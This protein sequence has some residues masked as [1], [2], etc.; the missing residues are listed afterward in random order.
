[1]INVV[2]DTWQQVAIIGGC[3]GFLLLVFLCMV[4]KLCPGCCLYEYC[5]LKAVYPDHKYENIRI[6]YK[7]EEKFPTKAYKLSPLPSTEYIYNLE[8]KGTDTVNGLFIMPKD[9]GSVESLPMSD[10]TSDSGLSKPPRPNLSFTLSY[11][12]K[13]EKLVINITEARNL[14]PK[15]ASGVSDFFLRV[16]FIISKK[17]RKRRQKKSTDEQE[18]TVETNHYRRSQDLEIQETLAMSMKS[19]ELKHAVLKF[20]ACEADRYSRCR[21]LGQVVINLKEISFAEEVQ[22]TEV[23]REVEKDSLGEIL[24][25]LSY[26]P[27]AE[28]ITVTIIKAINLLSPAVDVKYPNVYTK[29]VMVHDGKAL[30]KRRTATHGGT[31][32]PVFNEALSFDAPAEK[33]E[34]LTFAVTVMHAMSLQGSNEFDKVI[35][36]AWLGRDF[37]GEAQDHWFEVIRNP[38]KPIAKWYRLM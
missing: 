1:M 18:F 28:R 6:A 27:L 7:E 16:S 26:L 3:A 21:E 20:V 13:D 4:C 23:F 33:M 30:Q 37:S 35:G 25:S 29:V 9:Y 22:L 36:K 5:P 11:Y 31:T 15:D 2:L 14:P 32:E 17:R 34:N 19:S 10:G 38:R 24:V 8:H 12:N